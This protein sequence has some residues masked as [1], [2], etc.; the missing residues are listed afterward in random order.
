MRDSKSSCSNAPIYIL[1]SLS[2]FV[3]VVLTLAVHYMV[4]DIVRRIGSEYGIAVIAERFIDS[5]LILLIIVFIVVLVFTVAEN[6]K[7]TYFFR[8]RIYV[9]GGYVLNTC[10]ND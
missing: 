5:V 4:S 6:L 2:V 7:S 1:I 9:G 8:F 10:C 3:M